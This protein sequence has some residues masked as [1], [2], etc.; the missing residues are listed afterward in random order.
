ME[1]IR[2]DAIYKTKTQT[3]RDRGARCAGMVDGMTNII[4]IGDLK[5][6]RSE[7]ARK[8]CGHAGHLEYDP[9]GE[10]ISCK[11]C[12]KQVSAFWAFT[13]LVEQFKKA[14]EKL[15]E[16]ARKQ[17]EIEQK[18]IVL[19]AV[20]KVES[21]WR[22]RNMVPVCPHCKAGIYA[23]DGFGGTMTSKDFEDRRR[24]AKDRK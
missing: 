4:Q 13:M 20:I 24:A 17:A 12:D 9:V 21:A 22:R 2:I 19:R 14:K 16:Q 23:E 6:A 3:T 10:I 11:A 18:T 5:I 1:R 15:D 8:K 7:Q